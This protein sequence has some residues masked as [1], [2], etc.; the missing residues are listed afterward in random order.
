LFVSR[1]EI[2]VPFEYKNREALEKAKRHKREHEE[3]QK[4]RENELRDIDR[5]QAKVDRKKEIETELGKIDTF[6][7]ATQSE[8]NRLVS[9]TRC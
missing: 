4:T 1:F 5:D 3:A 2:V 7:E 8:I 6:K 9:A